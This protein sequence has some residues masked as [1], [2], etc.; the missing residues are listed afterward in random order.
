TATSRSLAR[1]LLAPWKTAAGATRWRSERVGWARYQHRF[2]RIRE[3]RPLTSAL[4]IKEPGPD[5]EKGV[6]YS[7]F[8][9][10][11]MKIVANH[12]AR[13]FFREY[14]LVGASS[15]SPTDHAVLG[16]LQGLSDEPIYIGVSHPDD[17]PSYRLWSPAIE[18][19][20]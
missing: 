3:R 19:L 1:V 20:P 10:N 17:I 16:N 12:D 6:L 4:L 7:A 8:E 5:G 15:Y 14:T 2:G 18:P 9:F 13:A 11:W